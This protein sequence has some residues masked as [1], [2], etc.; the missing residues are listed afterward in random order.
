MSSR[1]REGELRP[2]KSAR[3]ADTPAMR[4]TPPP[5]TPAP[6]APRLGRPRDPNADVAILRAVLDLASED[7]LQAVTIDAVAQRAGVGKATIYRRWTSKEAMLVDAWRTLSDPVVLPATG[8]L[9]ADVSS[10]LQ[11]L[12]VSNDV[13]VRRLLAQLVA[14]ARVDPALEATLADFLHER[15]APIRTWLRA[16]VERGELRADIDLDVLYELLVGPQFYRSLLT[17]R[18]MPKKAISQVIDLVLSSAV[19]TDRPDHKA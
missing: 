11:H 7:G 4:S 15:R 6:D 3:R 9:R 17:G 10:Y 1:L 18:S 14:A 2:A 8:D 16:A 12:A 5:A 19:R 13:R